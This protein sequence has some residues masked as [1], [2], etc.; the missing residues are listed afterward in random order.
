M[1]KV[2]AYQESLFVT[3]RD[4]RNIERMSEKTDQI[5][6]SQHHFLSDSP[7][8][9]Q[10]VMQHVSKKANRRFGDYRNQALAIDESSFRKSGKH[11]VGVSAQYNGN[12]GKVENSQ[13]GVYAS[14]SCGNQVGLINCRL[15]L[16]KDWIN[17]PQRCKKAGIPRQAIVEKTKIELALDM[18]GE[19]IDAG[20]EFG[21]INADSL[22]GQSYQFCRAI[23]QMGKDFV[24]DVHKDQQV[25]LADP[26]PYVPESSG[27]RGRRATR[28]KSEQSPV[29]VQQYLEGLRNKDFKEVKLRK[30]T[31]GWVKAKIHVLKV[32]VWDGKEEQA[33]ERTLIIRKSLKKNEVKFALSNIEITRKTPQQFAFMQGQRFWI[34]RAFEDCKGEL[35]M[36]DY[37][38]RKYNAWYHHQALVMMALDYINHVKDTTKETIP[39]LSVRDIRLQIIAML[40]GQGAEME[41]EIDQMFFRHRQRVSDIL[42]YYPDND[43]LE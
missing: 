27:K 24:V 12:L 43:F 3:E 29:E 23:D 28:L 8:S 20:V 39:L 19:S 4:K 40:K 22:Y 11:S 18:I 1:D 37:Q 25:F 35:G 10:Q 38:V 26:K 5:Y 30:G 16:P 7:W 15:F 42:R 36:A 17:D 32:W 21:W 33:R 31:K 2:L 34:E 6:Q 13:T 41:K 9:A 14:L